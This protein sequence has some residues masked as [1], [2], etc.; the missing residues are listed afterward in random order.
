L[1]HGEATS[2]IFDGDDFS[3]SEGD[4]S[5]DQLWKIIVNSAHEIKPEFCSDVLIYLM[6]HLPDYT[7]FEKE[8]VGA[9]SRVNLGYSLLK[10]LDEATWGIGLTGRRN[11][12][13]ENI[14]EIA[15]W[16]FGEGRHI[17]N[18]VV[19]TLS[20]PER[21]PLG[22]F[23]LLLFRLYCSADRGG[24]FFNLQRAISLHSNP[25]APTSGLTTEIA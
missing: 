2:N 19:S 20:K 8:N 11:N 23:D 13:D 14:S 12:S 18:G 21:G 10:L 5:R 17:S 16:V 4:F 6:K 3:F 22:L 7:F 1:F 15:E 9:G 25:N 24:S